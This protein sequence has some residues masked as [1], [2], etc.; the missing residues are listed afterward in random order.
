ML[1]IKETTP[2]KKFL[3]LSATPDEL[4]K[5]FLEYS[6]ISYQIIDP[7]REQ[8]YCFSSPPD[9]KWRQIS[10]PMT[11]HFPSNLEPNLR[12]SYDWLRENGE[13]VVLQ[14]FQDNPGSKGAIILN[15]IAAVKKLVPFFK[16]IFEPL[17]FRVRENTGLT[18]ETEKAQSVVEADLLLGTSTIDVGVDFKINF[19]VFEGADAGNFIQRFGRIGRH[20]GFTNYQAYALVPKF[21]VQRLF[22][23]EKSPLKNGEEYDKVTF[24]EAIRNSYPFVNEFRKYPQRWGAIQS[25][26]VY[27]ELLRLKQQYP[28]AASNFGNKIQ[29][30]LG[31]SVKKKFGQ[32]KH[33]IEEG[34]GKV[35][36]EARSFRGSSQL[37]CAIYDST[38]PDEPERDRFKTYNL[39]GILSNFTFQ[40]MEKSD[41]LRRLKESGLSI[42]RYE[43]ALCYLRL[44]G[45]REVREDWRFVFPEDIN[46][47]AISGQVQVL[48]G[49]EVFQPH[50]SGIN[51]I[52]KVL[53]VRKLVCFVS[54]RDRAYL[55]AKLGL[56]IHFQAYSLADK[57]STYGKTP[58]TI[59]FGK[60]ALMLE[61][62]LWY[63][64]PKED[65]GWIC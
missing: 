34:K 64:K 1:L 17:G 51:S 36:D 44:T 8:K 57:Y 46:D 52:N 30:S 61:T 33:C 42:N 58:Y 37:N 53:S 32:I 15:S 2:D 9:D 65:Q 16:D 25:A 56:P 62:L 26:C 40:W 47:I 49:L 29:Q 21:I 60:S 59:A 38:N 7:V 3:F 54:D 10:Q 35:I 4:L 22:D 28:E 12:S 14:F 43:K 31:A 45:Y 39:P 55:R 48:E 11:L 18:G 13:S 23:L 6:G 50:G 24:T 19:L 20:E 5:E 63:W 27:S 41:F